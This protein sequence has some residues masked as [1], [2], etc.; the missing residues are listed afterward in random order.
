MEPKNKNMRNELETEINSLNCDR[1]L[2]AFT[3]KSW[4]LMKLRASLIFAIVLGPFL[5]KFVVVPLSR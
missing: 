2:A 4:F 1:M 3:S 5:L